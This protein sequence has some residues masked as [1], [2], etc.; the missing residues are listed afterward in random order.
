MM[1]KDKRGEQ[2]NLGL[3]TGLV[4]GIASLVI[5]V[6]I[7]FVIVQTLTS[8]DLLESGRESVTVTNETDAYMNET[9]YAT[10]G[11]LVENTV[12]FTLT[13]I[14]GVENGIYNITI[15]IA[16]GTI[17]NT[18]LVTNATFPAYDNVSLS[19]G[20][21]LKTSEEISTS[22]LSAN[23]TAGID[24]ISSKIPTVLLV[25]A[26]VLIIGVLSLLVNVWRRMDLGGG[27]SL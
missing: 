14:W 21:S 10:A 9:S 26:V 11:S 19:Y 7:A 2:V 20:Y 12:S 1:L 27:S 22:K 18:G 25:A 6:I 23:F 16:N 5:G 4:F 24:N 13:A 15:P 8:A 17:S 3:I